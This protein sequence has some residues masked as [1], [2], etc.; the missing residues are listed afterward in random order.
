MYV[1]RFLNRKMRD[2]EK[3]KEPTF[4][5]FCSLSIYFLFL[6]FVVNPN[7]YVDVIDQHT[8]RKPHYILYNIIKHTDLCRPTQDYF[9]FYSVELRFLLVLFAEHA[10]RL[11]NIIHYYLTHNNLLCLHI[12]Q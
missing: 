10:F 6:R 5:T 3:K 11:F 12:F 1:A 4:P 2:G 8:L 7:G 9:I